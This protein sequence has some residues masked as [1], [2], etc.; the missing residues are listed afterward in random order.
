MK[1]SQAPLSRLLMLTIPT[2]GIPLVFWSGLLHSYDLVFEAFDFVLL[3]AQLSLSLPL[4][5]MK[6]L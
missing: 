6:P 3:D 4:L 1:L 2:R 5:L